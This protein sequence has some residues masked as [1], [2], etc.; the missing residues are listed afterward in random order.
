M[1]VLV[2]AVVAITASVACGDVDNGLWYSQLSP[3]LLNAQTFGAPL[4]DVE[5][6]LANRLGCTA[7]DDVLTYANVAS[8][9]NF[10]GFADD[11]TT[12]A[13]PLGYVVMNFQARSRNVRL[14]LAQESWV[15]DRDETALMLHDWPQELAAGAGGAP[16]AVPE[17]M[18]LIMLSAG[19]AVMASRRL[20]TASPG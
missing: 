1:K 13:N 10:D 20:R 8:D 15:F 3:A 19:A 14:V 7:F 17:P 11:F 12:L 9:A 18:T 5:A 4:D 2:A 16:G 6:R